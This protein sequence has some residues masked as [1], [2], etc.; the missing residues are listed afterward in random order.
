MTDEGKDVKPVG[1]VGPVGPVG[2]VGR[3][4]VMVPFDCALETHDIKE[5]QTGGHFVSGPG[6]AGGDGKHVYILTLMTPD[7]TAQVARVQ[8]SSVGMAVCLME[9][10]IQNTLF[11]AARN[12]TLTAMNWDAHLSLAEQI[13]RLS[14][15]LLFHYGAQAG[16]GQKFRDVV[17]QAIYYLHPPWYTRLWWM[18]TRKGQGPGQ[19]QG[20]G[21]GQQQ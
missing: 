18:V 14:Q 7:G 17:G 9:E 21:Q 15:H 16:P 5:F 6:V 20:Q 3:L 2:Q 4:G 12:T 19:G 1:Q 8:S 10:C 11:A 13:G